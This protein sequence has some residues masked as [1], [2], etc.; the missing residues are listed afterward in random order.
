MLTV[1]TRMFEGTG[2][3]ARPY[4]LHSL[5]INLKIVNMWWNENQTESNYSLKKVYPHDVI[6]PQEFLFCTK[7]LQWK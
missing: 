3:G 4:A 7:I 6:C 1:M 5:A 2:A